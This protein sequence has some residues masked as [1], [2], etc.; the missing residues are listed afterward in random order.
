MFKKVEVNGNRYSYEN[1][2]TGWK[3]RWN[4]NVPVIVY[5]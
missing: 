2:E 1:Y 5:R 3:A 4:N